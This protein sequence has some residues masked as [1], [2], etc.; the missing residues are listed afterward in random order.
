[1]GSR[2]P[3]RADWYDSRMSV[4]VVVPLFNGLP[5]I[6]DALHSV[7]EQALAPEEIVVVDDGSTDGSPSVV[8][9]FDGVRLVANDTKGGAAARNLGARLTSAT[10]SEHGTDLALFDRG[11]H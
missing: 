8:Q 6:R 7:R 9:A 5:W 2:F 4:S 10:R 3:I 11:T 1:M